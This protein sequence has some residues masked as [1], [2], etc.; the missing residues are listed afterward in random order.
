[1]PKTEKTEK[2]F[3]VTHIQKHGVEEA[4]N[5]SSYVPRKGE[6]IIYDPDANNNQARLKLGDGDKVAKDLPFIDAKLSKY[7]EEQLTSIN[8]NIDTIEDDISN[9]KTTIGDETSGLVKD[10][11]DLETAL[12]EIELTPGAAATIEIGTVTSGTTPSVTNSGNSTNATF[13]FVLPKGDPGKDGVSITKTEII[14]G[15]LYVTYSTGTSVNAGAVSGEDSSA[16]PEITEQDN[17]KLLSVENGVISFTK[18]QLLTPSLETYEDGAMCI[19]NIDPNANEVE[20]YEGEGGGCGF[21][22]LTPGES[23]A[24]FDAPHDGPS[25]ALCVRVLDNTGVYE[26]SAYSNPIVYISPDDLNT[27]IGITGI[28][29]N[30]ISNTYHEIKLNYSDN[31]SS[32]FL[33][34]G[35]EEE[36]D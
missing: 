33:R 19:F 2:K 3:L 8:G 18:K 10:L 14:D 21:A 32:V 25:R 15:Q 5:G 16:L 26:P 13:N 30:P 6:L 4:W 27:F 1:M 22:E 20:F 23:E 29:I 24:W 34:L 11:E 35:L 31:T 28:T 17:G 7:I 9:L 36:N 12:A